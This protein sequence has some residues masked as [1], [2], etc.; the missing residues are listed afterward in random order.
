MKTPVEI[1][2]VHAAPTP[3]AEAEIRRGVNSLEESYSGITRCQV[4]VGVPARRQPSGNP[5]EVRVEITVPGSNLA[6]MSPPGEPPAE[7]AL[8]VALRETFAAMERRLEQWKMDRG[9]G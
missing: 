9:R 5:Y 1:S 3:A 7:E 2:F 6:V 4:F 8:H